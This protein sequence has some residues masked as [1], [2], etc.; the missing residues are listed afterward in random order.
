[1]NSLETVYKTRQRHIVGSYGIDDRKKINTADKHPETADYR[2]E[3][4]RFTFG[5]C[6]RTQYSS[7]TSG[8]SAVAEAAGGAFPL[9]LSPAALVLVLPGDLKVPLLNSMG[10][11]SGTGD[12]GAVWGTAVA[13]V[14][15]EKCP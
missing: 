12:V 15:A 14:R 8:S 1:L 13:R 2:S 4:V 11:L 6:S 3:D 5:I 10:L 7:S 9:V